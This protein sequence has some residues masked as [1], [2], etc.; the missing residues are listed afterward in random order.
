M[1]MPAVVLGFDLEDLLDEVL[2]RD[3]EFADS[4]STGLDV[5]FLN[6]GGCVGLVLLGDALKLPGQLAGLGVERDFPALAT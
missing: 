3:L 5:R 6:C 4:P 2:H 1:P